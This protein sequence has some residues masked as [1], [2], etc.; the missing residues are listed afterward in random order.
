M[1]KQPLNH[2]AYSEPCIFKG[3][4]Q[5]LE[6]PPHAVAS[7]WRSVS[8]ASSIKVRLL[9]FGSKPKIPPPM[10][11][12]ATV[13]SPYHLNSRVCVGQMAPTWHDTMQGR[14]QTRHDKHN[15]FTKNVVNCQAELL[16]AML[17]RLQEGLP[18]TET[19]TFLCIYR[20]PFPNPEFPRSNPNGH[21]I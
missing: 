17:G 8:N 1:Q 14:I 11:G 12:M 19:E 20:A 2:G 18:G 4:P 6:P 3:V 5:V 15:K 9:F 13:P 10:L 7:T 16:P 21:K